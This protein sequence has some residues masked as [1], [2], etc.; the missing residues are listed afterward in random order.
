MEPRKPASCAGRRGRGRGRQY[1]RSQN[2]GA[3]PRDLDKPAHRGRRHRHVRKGCPGTWEILV[4]SACNGRTVQREA[5]SMRVAAGSRSA[6][7]GAMKQG[8]QPEGTLW[9]K[10]R[11]REY[12]TER[13]NDGRDFELA[14]CLNETRTDSETGEE[15]AG[16]GAHHARS[17]HRHGLAARGV[18]PNAQGRRRGRRWTKRDRIRRTA[19]GQ[20]PVA[21]RSRQV[22]DVPGAARAAGPHPEGRWEANATHRHS[23]LR[24]QGPAARGGDG[25]GGRLRAIV[26]RLLVRLSAGSLGASGAAKPCSKR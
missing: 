25:A 18:P 3:K 15:Q 2:A 20:P 17:P 6:A 24:G 7:V 11:R 23:D 12:G 4:A 14:N 5:T 8:N 22:R 1:R 21:A 16:R 10:G 26:S 13:R 9:S 19:G